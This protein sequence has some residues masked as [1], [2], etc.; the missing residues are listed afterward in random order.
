MRCPSALRSDKP[1]LWSPG[2]GR[3]VWVMLRAAR[4]G[5]VATLRRMLRLNPALARCHFE[6]RTPLE[7]AVG[8]NQLAAAKLLFGHQA[9]GL[10]LEVHQPLLA[11]AAEKGF[12]AM[13]NLLQ[14]QLPI[15][16]RGEPLA[17]AI[18]SRSL[19][20]VRQLLD[21][22]PSLLT[23]PDSRG[24]L[25]IHWAT[26]TRQ[27][28]VIDELHARGA[29]LNAA[30][31]DGARPIQ[32]A[33]GDYLFRGWRD[34]PAGNNAT[35]RQIIAH[36]RKRG[37]H[38]DLCSASYIGDLAQATRLLAEDPALANRPSP[39]QSYYPCSGNPLRN[40]AAGGHLAIVQLLLAHGAD[41]NLPVDGIAP[42]GQALHEA[43]CHGH[44]VIV[45]LLLEHGARPNVPV[46]SS[47]DTLSAAMRRGDSE[48]V[49]LLASRGAARSL[50]I[51]AYYGDLIP[52]AAML[53]ANPR[54]ANDPGALQCAA[55]EGHEAFVRLL[56]HHRPR[57]ARQVGVG[58][59]TPA[60][61]ELLFA[62]GM[63][64]NHRD[65]LDVTP[66]HRFAR[67]GAVANAQL[68]LARGAR[69]DSMDDDLRLTPLGWAERYRQPAM[70][71]L[72]RG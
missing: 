34:V 14:A 4:E 68:F 57:L 15:S 59:K 27:P 45:E 38:C 20:Q 53:A 44:R 35:P 42:L 10:S 72:L 28:R 64:P 41:P 61:T 69:R 8:A 37:A 62:H 33:N 51:L 30:R 25:P 56:L 9:D 12:T 52:A 39:Y 65:W 5:D 2:T 3:Q 19:R 47:A 43:V 71:E 32:L 16:T 7:F 58:G 60:I 18:R 67:H 36:L 26:M 49:A 46:E 6:Y 31:P 48:M 66:L 21:A 50:E 70:V 24:N 13:Q 40:A 29:D 63:N 17:T 55:E 23:A 11:L 54:L 1:L 22:D